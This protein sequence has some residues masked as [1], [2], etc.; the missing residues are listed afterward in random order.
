MFLQRIRGDLNLAESTIGVQTTRK[1][2]DPFIILK[3]RDFIR[4]LSRST[5]LEQAVR[6]LEDDIFADIIEMH[7]IKKKRFIKRRNRLV[8]HEGE[9]L[10]A[11]EL[12]TDC[13]I[14]ILGKTV[15][16]V[17]KIVDECI[18]DNIHPAYTIKRLIVMQKLA[19]D[20]TKKDVSWEPFLPKAKKKALS[21]RWKP[22]N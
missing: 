3:A 22:I 17:R 12:A 10:K 14:T 21:K 15:S 7:L 13:H 2:F 19:S 11:I 20:P 4:L 1:T 8:G 5:P 6:V 9:T 16:A 18:H